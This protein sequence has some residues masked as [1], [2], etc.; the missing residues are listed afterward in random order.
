[1]PVERLQLS[2]LLLATE[3]L[4]QRMALSNHSRH[5]VHQFQLM[6]HPRLATERPRLA[7]EHLRPAM[8][9]QDTDSPLPKTPMRSASS[10]VR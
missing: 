6:E 3:H 8:E 4:H 1:M 10:S 5:T 7:M 9:R 2:N